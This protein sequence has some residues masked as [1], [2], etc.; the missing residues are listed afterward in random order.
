MNITSS[1]KTILFVCAMMLAIGCYHVQRVPQNVISE[2]KRKW[3]RVDRVGC[4]IDEYD[5]FGLEMRKLVSEYQGV[6]SGQDILAI[7]S[8]YAAEFEPDDIT[9]VYQFDEMSS[10][11]VRS[12]IFD[13][14]SRIDGRRGVGDVRSENQLKRKVRQVYVGMDGATDSGRDPDGEISSVVGESG[15]LSALKRE[16]SRL[17]NLNNAN[18]VFRIEAGSGEAKQ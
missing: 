5:R 10:A 9:Y 15:P 7:M 1:D 2:Y 8:D 13:G 4:P 18:E 16:F 12:F 14:E 6:I 11:S 3:E 17:R